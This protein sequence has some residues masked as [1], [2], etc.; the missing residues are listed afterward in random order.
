VRS[1]HA[2]GPAPPVTAAVTFPG[3]RWATTEPRCRPVGNHPC[4]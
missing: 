1:G 3:R 2:D 4:P